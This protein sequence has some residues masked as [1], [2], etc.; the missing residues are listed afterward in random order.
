MIARAREGK[1]VQ[2]GDGE[3]L[4][5]VT[6][7]DNAA[8]AH[9]LAADRLEQGAAC[10]GRAY[11]ISQG[12]PVRLWPFLGEILAFPHGRYDDQVDSFSQFLTWAAKPRMRFHIG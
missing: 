4:V 9:L 11:F 10:A 6:Y 1:L 3:N 12:E 2:V 8:E 5:D 7:I